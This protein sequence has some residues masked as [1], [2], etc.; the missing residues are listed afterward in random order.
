MNELILVALAGEKRQPRLSLRL[1]TGCGE[2]QDAGCESNS[3]K[4]R[5]VDFSHMTGSQPSAGF[6][7]ACVRIKALFKDAPTKPVF[8]SKLEQ[9]NGNTIVKM[10]V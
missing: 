4:I 3:W 8:H 2:Q 6:T 1:I 10:N 5:A 7:A 9:M